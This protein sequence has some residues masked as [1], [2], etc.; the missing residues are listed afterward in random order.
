[1]EVRTLSDVRVLDVAGQAVRLA[2]QWRTH[3]AVVVWL[4]H[5][6]CVYCAEQAREFAARLEDI[7][8]AGGRLIFVGNGAPRHAAEFQR[9]VAPGTTVLTDP[10]LASYRAI[11]ARR[12]VLKTIGPQSWGSALRALRTGARQSS[13]KG[14]PF[15]QGGVLVITPA[16]VAVYSYLSKSAGD[17]PPVADVL[18]ALRQIGA[19]QGVGGAPAP[20]TAPAARS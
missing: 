6:G 16:Q 20:A 19:A 1:M 11:R 3:P 5:F 8:R 4:R 18:S 15:Q 17:H 2:D 13:V 10:Q 9:R 12:G 7:E 14:H